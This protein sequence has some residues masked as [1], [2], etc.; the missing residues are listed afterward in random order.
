MLLY[1]MSLPAGTPISELLTGRF[2]GF[3]PR[4]DYM[5]HPLSPNF[6]HRRKPIIPTQC[7]MSLRSVHVLEFL[8]HKNPEF[9][10]L[11]LLKGRIPWI[12]FI[13][14]CVSCI[15][16]IYENVSKYWYHSVIGRKPHSNN[17][18]QTFRG[19]LGKKTI[20]QIRKLRGVQKWD[21]RPVCACKL[22]GAL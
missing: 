7:R 8:T 22:D 4:R 1:L 18:R 16:G 2:C 9:C 5:F 14:F 3:L 21:G 12:I 15:F 13:K 10:K 17:F 11:I 6:V 19:S 20:G